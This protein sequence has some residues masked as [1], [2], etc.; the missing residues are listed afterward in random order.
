MSNGKLLYKDTFSHHFPL[1]YYYIYL[2]FP[3][4]GSRFSRSISVFRLSLT[5][6]YIFSFLLVFFNLKNKKSYLGFSLMIVILGLFFTLYHGNLVLSENFLG[7]SILSI[8][9]LTA[10]TLL[11]WENYDIKKA[12]SSTFFAFVGFWS[13]PL[14]CPLFLIPFFLLKKH[15]VKKITL[16]VVFINLLPIFYFLKSGQLKFFLEQAIWFNFSVYPKYY[17]D[18]IASYSNS[19]ILQNLLCFL[20]NELYFFTHFSNSHQLFQFILHLS[21]IIIGVKISKR[22]NLKYVLAFL[23]LFCVSRVREVKIIPGQIFNFGIFP[24]LTLSSSTFSIILILFYQK[25]KILALILISF[26]LTLEVINIRPIIKQSLKSGYNYHVFWSYR[27]D[28]G[29]IINDLSFKNESI[30]IYPHDVDLYFF[31]QR[32]PPDKFTY[33]F[34]WIDSVKK[35]RQEREKILKDS[36]PAIIYVGSLKFKNDPY[37]YKNLFPNLLDQYSQILKE[38]KITNIWI[39]NDLLERIIPPYSI[40]SKSKNTN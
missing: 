33:W 37:Y 40:Y 35:Y 26:F 28:I 10:P 5:L 14:A 4:W 3:F 13:Q 20:N 30:L 9:W 27:E 38:N 12:I 32:L 18:L 7:I 2:F 19:I 11:D 22:K 16:L 15:E 8:F 25:Y 34:P 36:P 24:F 31:S 39:R 23:I 6:L 17:N 1:P 29:K 21:F